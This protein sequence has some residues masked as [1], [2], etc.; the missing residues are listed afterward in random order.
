LYEIIY[1]FLLGGIQ[2]KEK[3]EVD[4]RLMTNETWCNFFYFNRFSQ[5]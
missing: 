1:H 2:D 3:T 5:E 4:S